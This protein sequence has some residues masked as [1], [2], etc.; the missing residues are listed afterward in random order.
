MD[1]TDW[2][3]DPL[4]KHIHIVSN[5]SHEGLGGWCPQFNPMWHITKVELWALGFITAVHS[6]PSLGDSPD[7]TSFE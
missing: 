7:M 3:A 1:M 2:V 6:K 4:Q 5:A